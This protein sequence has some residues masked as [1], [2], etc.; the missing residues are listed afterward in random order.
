VPTCEELNAEYDDDT[1]VCQDSQGYDLNALDPNQAPMRCEDW[2]SGDTNLDLVDPYYIC[3][4]WHELYGVLRP[5]T[6]TTT[7]APTTLP[8]MSPTTRAPSMLFL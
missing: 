3:I 2:D 5:T 8:T 7:V 6:T 4:K 1:V